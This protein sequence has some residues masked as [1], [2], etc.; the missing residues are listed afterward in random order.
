MV[1]VDWVKDFLFCP[2]SG[3]SIQ[4]LQVSFFKV[5]LCIILLFDCMMESQCC[6]R[7]YQNAFVST[8]TQIFYFVSKQKNI[9]YFF[10]T[11]HIILWLLQTS[12]SI[13]FDFA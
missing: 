3:D 11:L 9:F 10:F 8:E 13:F 1:S 2:N 12:C 4:S 5:L 7:K 6:L